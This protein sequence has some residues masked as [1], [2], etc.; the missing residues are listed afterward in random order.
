MHS[1]T[2]MFNFLRNFYEGNKTKHNYAENTNT[3]YKSP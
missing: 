2:P 3:E 1:D